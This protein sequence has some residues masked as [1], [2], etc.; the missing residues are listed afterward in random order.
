LTHRRAL[1]AF[2]AGN[3]GVRSNQGEAVL[4][5]LNLLYGN[6]P[7]SHGVALRAVCSKLPPVNVGMAIGAVFAHIRKNW[8]KVALDTL[9]LGVHAP[10]RVA[11]FVVVEFRHGP[12]GLPA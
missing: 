10:E 11:S 8:L 6:L 2:L 4:M 1:V 3:R 12:D 7:A 9:H 5:L